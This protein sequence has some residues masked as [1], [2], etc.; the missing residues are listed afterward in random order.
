MFAAPTKPFVLALFQVTLAITG[1]APEIEISSGAYRKPADVGAIT[2]RSI[3]APGSWDIEYAWP[4]HDRWAGNILCFA[5]RNK[6]GGEE[7]V[8]YRRPSYEIDTRDQR[9]Y[10]IGSSNDTLYLLGINRFEWYWDG[11]NIIRKDRE[12]G[13][14]VAYL[15]ETGAT[16]RPTSD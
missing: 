10:L 8:T 4:E 11:A 5:I 16:T 14:S 15:R 9:I 1:C 2:V 3:N 6:R 13:E 12:T 7:H